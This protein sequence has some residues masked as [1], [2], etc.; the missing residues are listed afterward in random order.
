MFTLSGDLIPENPVTRFAPSVTGWLHIGHVAHAAFVW[1]VARACGA[2]VILRLDDHDRGRF[3]P[4][5]ETAILDDLEWLKL[6]PDERYG[7]RYS[8]G[9]YAD[10]YAAE[11]AHLSSRYRTYACECTRAMIGE[12]SPQAGSTGGYS[13]RCRD[14]GLARGP[15]RGVRVVVEPEVEKFTDVLLG[16]L[17]QDAARG[18]DP[19]LVDRAG[20]WTYHMSVVGDDLH[21][22]VNL[23]IRG[24][25][26]LDS[27]GRQIRLGRMVG[28]TTPPVFLH[29]QL[30]KDDPGNKLS[31]R[32]GALGV[33]ELR[34]GGTTPEELLGLAVHSVGLTTAPNPLTADE[35]PGLFRLTE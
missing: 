35:L 13:G 15:G 3:R 28:R 22:G 4:E 17:E 21:E 30:I 33:R 34:A 7:S 14:R 2:R 25:D 12:S 32:D 29:H 16:E 8:Q 19:L 10:R 24:E 31:K 5:Y 6:E 20:N 27:T 11:M 26:L 9:E 23:V 1:G 18:G